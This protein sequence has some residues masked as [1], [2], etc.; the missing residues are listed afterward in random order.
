MKIF[1]S[2]KDILKDLQVAKVQVRLRA[3]EDVAVGYCWDDMNQEIF[4][5]EDAKKLA[6]E[7]YAK[8]LQK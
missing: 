2:V 6:D 4:T 7:Q 1:S 8:M 3:I 5:G